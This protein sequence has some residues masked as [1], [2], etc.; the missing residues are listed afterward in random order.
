MSD[1]WTRSHHLSNFRVKLN[2]GLDQAAVTCYALAQHFRAGEGRDPN[3]KDYLLFAST[4]WADVIKEG[5]S[6]EALWKIR[7]LK[8]TNLW[9]EGNRSVVDN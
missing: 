2:R 4:Y 6:E 9:C 7:R 5:H 8:P 3:E 1:R